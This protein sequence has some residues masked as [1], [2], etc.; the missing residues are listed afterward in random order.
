MAF[1]SLTNMSKGEISPELQAR[2]DTAQYGAGLKRCRNFIL[3]RYGGAS[4]RPGFRFVGEVDALGTTPRYVPFQFNI[5]QAYVMALDEGAMRLLA[6]GGMVIEENLK[7]TAI[8]KAA[9][10]QVTSAFHAFIVG[11]KL[12]FYNVVG[13]TEIN[14]RT[15]TVATVIDANNFTVNINSTTFTTFVS[16]DG[17]I[18]GAPPVVPPPPVP[19]PAPPAPP[20]PPDTVGGGGSGGGIGGGDD[21]YDDGTYK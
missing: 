19:P 8:T 20:P 3:Q 12:T 15:G 1:L 9:T 4:F 5:E 11:D 18:R 2:I 7:I 21:R 17:A 16:S 10:A 13:M 6:R 14:G